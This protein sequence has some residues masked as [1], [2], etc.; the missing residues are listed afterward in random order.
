VSFATYG[1]LGG[2]NG[3]ALVELFDVS[4][5]LIRTLVRGAFAAGVH[6]A[7]WDGRDRDGLHVPAGLYFL[8]ALTGGETAELKLL[9]IR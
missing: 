2:G 9:V 5:R 6:S 1:G 8:R 4:G 3:E 7:S